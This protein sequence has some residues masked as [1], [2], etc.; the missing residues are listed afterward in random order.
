[1]PKQ[2]AGKPLSKTELYARIAEATEL[3]KKQVEAVFEA[4]KK[5]IEEA[6]ST[7]GPGVIQLP[8]L[9][10]IM[11]VVRPATKRRQVRNPATGEMVW[12]E[13]KPEK[14]V[15]KARVLKGLKDMVSG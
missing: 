15:P 5:E 9:V 8:G 3:T 7:K 6:V 12:A 1:M 13:A 4:F 14:V 10:K 11:R 2:A